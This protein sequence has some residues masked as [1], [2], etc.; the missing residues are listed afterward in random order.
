MRIAIRAILLT[1]CRSLDE[2]IQRIR[3]FAAL[4]G[5]ALAQLSRYLFGNVANPT[6]R[7]VKANDANWVAVLAFQQIVDNSKQAPAGLG[8]TGAGDSQSLRTARG[9]AFQ[10]TPPNLGGPA[11]NWPCFSDSVDSLNAGTGARFDG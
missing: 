11:E 1:R 6:F 5:A 10:E 3:Q 9:V 8:A 2:L 4:I 7:D